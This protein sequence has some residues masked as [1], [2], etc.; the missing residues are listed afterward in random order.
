MV[1]IRDEANVLTDLLGLVRDVSHS[2]PFC[3]D[4][5]MCHHVVKKKRKNGRGAGTLL[6]RLSFNGASSNIK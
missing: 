6:L 2:L 4:E 5:A 3:P 1:A